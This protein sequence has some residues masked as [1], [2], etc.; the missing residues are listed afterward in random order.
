M[1][2]CSR[3]SLPPPTPVPRTR[4]TASISSIKIIAGAVFFAILKRSRTRLAPTPTKSSTNSEPEIVKKGTLASPDTALA[5][6]V[7]P[8]PGAP[9]KST[10]FGM[11]A[12]MSMNFFGFFKKSTISESSSFASFAPATSLKV[13]LLPLSSGSIMRALLCPKVNACMPAPLTCRIK[14]HNSMSTNKS[15]KI[16]GASVASQ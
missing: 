9:I 15:G 2:V 5:K 10:P 11:R 3:S 14:N 4:P 1:R 16:N 7:L 8:V 13:I 6:S 12:P